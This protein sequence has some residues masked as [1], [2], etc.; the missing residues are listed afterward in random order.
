VIVRDPVAD[1]LRIFV[2]MAAPLL[3]DY[4]QLFP[5]FIHACV[6]LPTGTRECLLGVSDAGG[7]VPLGEDPL[8]I[9]SG[10]GTIYPSARLTAPLPPLDLVLAVA[11]VVRRQ[12]LE[13]LEAGHFQLL[14]AALLQACEARM[15]HKHDADIVEVVGL[16][17]RRTSTDFLAAFRSLQDHIFVGLAD[18]RNCALAS[19]L[20]HIVV[21][22][23]P[24]AVSFLAAPAV[25]GSLILLFRPPMSPRDPASEALVLNL[26]TELS[27]RG[28]PFDRAVSDALT[29]FGRREPALFEASGL[30]VAMLMRR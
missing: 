20:L 10:F 25:Q 7:V 18:P 29:A 8:V 30:K 21:V 28:H 2:G 16:Q 11:D 17:L 9:R 13:E 24:G 14:I 15:P 12:S 5:V 6:S 3:I 26:L 23:V 27:R 1:V 19:T 22:A 4:P